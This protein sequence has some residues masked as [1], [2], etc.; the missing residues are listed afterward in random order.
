VDSIPRNPSG[1]M[2]K[3]VLREPYWRGHDRRI[4]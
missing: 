1:K 3:R 2:L 4:I